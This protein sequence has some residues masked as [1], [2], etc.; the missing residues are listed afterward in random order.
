MSNI[1]L[2]ELP[3]PAEALEQNLALE[4][5]RVW[6]GGGEQHVSI[7]NNVWDDPANWG[8]LLVDLAKHIAKSYSEENYD[9]TLARIREGFDAE[10][11][12]PTD[13]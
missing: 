8:I 11:E 7:A 3:V 2:R 6:A 13:G 5:V 4:L 9:S 12:S 10:W 1:N